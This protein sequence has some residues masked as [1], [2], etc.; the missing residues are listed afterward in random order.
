[1]D[2]KAQNGTITGSNYEISEF[3]LFQNSP[4]P[5]KDET[6]FR[7]NLN[8]EDEIQLT[9]YDINGKRLKQLKTILPAGQHEYR[10]T[11][12]DLNGS[13]LYFFEIQTNSTTA[14]KKFVQM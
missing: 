14:M 4:N 2:Y 6:T 7:F 12:D 13:G 9:I 8:Q 11:K 10:I 3:E 1:M 5:F